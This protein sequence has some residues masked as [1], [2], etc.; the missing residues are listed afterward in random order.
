ML[1]QVGAVAL[2][3]LEARP[4]RVE[5]TTAPGLPG[6]RI[7]GLPDTAVREA[8][9]R[10]RTALQGQGFRWPDRRLVASLSPADVPKVGSGFDLAFALGVLGATQEVPLAPLQDVVAV[11]E[12]GLDGACRPV[13]GVLPVAREA[14]RMGARLLLVPDAAAVE[15]SLVDGLQVVPVRDLREAV[16]VLRGEL[17]ARDVD[18]LPVVAEP[19]GPDL[20]EVRGQE[21]A[22]RVLEVA[23]AGGHH[24]LLVGPPGCG[25]TML[26]SRLVGLLPD[27][28]DALALEVATIR[29]VAGLRRPSHGLSRRPPFRAPHHGTSIA[30]LVGGGSGLARPG[31]VSLAHGGVLF[32]DE[33]LEAP[34]AVLDALRQPIEQG[35][36]HLIRSRGA[37]RYPARFQLVAASN[38][39]P[40][41]HDGDPRRPCTCRPGLAERYRARL[42]GP[43]LDRVD[44]QV[45]L[46]PV[47]EHDLLGPPAGESTAVV[48]ARVAAARTFADERRAAGHG[49]LTAATNAR[50]DV[51]ALRGSIR[52]QALRDA[53]RA[54]GALGL[55]ARSLGAVLRVSR[56]IADLAGEELVAAEHVHEALAHRL[57][58]LVPA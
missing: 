33:L 20:A 42:S 18:P 24:L 49:D 41:G 40:C 11:G 44:L 57:P 2:V 35:E 19:P 30:G 43:L 51:E 7:V 3:G 15:A 37:V 54:M 6:M 34:R 50:A 26:A 56:T 38:A 53:L 58:D 31:E 22:R 46:Q 9:D 10:V 27:L 13:R 4:V 45:R 29:S 55:T 12:V 48:A 39:C 28:D 1:A 5:C 23:A 32:L 8:A 25:K 21:L 16:G 17:P 36:V 52:P 14:A 47:Q